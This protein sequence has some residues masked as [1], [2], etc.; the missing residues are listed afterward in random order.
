MKV[1]KE[2]W[3][4]TYPN[5]KLGIT[6]HDIESKFKD[7]DKRVKRNKKYY[8]EEKERR[9]WYAF[10]DNKLVGYCLAQLE[11]GV[12]KINSIYILK[13]YQGFGIGSK[14][15]QNAL[16]YLKSV[17]VM[18]ECAKYNKSTIEFY[19]KFGFK[20]VEEKKDK[21]EFSSGSKMPLIIMKKDAK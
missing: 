20:I 11:N 16:E 1:N 19:K 4:T 9:Q 3:L 6:K 17:N 18:L 10:I 7:F 12:G 14:L 15:L 21:L 5:P 13:K 8:L 2:V